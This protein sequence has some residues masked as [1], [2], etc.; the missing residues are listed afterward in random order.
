M[1]NNY[2][3]IYFELESA[4][5]LALQN[6]ENKHIKPKKVLLKTILNDVLNNSDINLSNILSFFQGRGNCWI[7]VIVN[8]NCEIWNKIKNNLNV[9][10]DH[11]YFYEFSSYLDLFEEKGFA[12]LKF[13]HIT[14]R[15]IQFHLRFMGS[16]NSEHL[17]LNVKI[18]KFNSLVNLEGIPHKLELENGFG[19]NKKD[20]KIS[21]NNNKI[22]LGNSPFINIM[23]L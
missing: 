7:K 21:T 22:D 13:S 10:K 18:D 20:L 16:R 23:E 9:D 6:L 4:I 8:D 5:N 12:W 3:D 2:D 19:F 1:N 11:E 17:K 15:Y 14:K